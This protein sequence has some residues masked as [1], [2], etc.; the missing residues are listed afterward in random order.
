MRNSGLD[1]LVDPADWNEQLHEL[2]VFL[3]SFPECFDDYAAPAAMPCGADLKGHQTLAGLR[4]R[5]ADMAQWHELMARAL[6]GA[7]IRL[8]AHLQAG[9]RRL[10]ERSRYHA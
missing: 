9:G 7:E 8:S 5:L 2:T 4:D 1:C 3:T 6:R 10:I